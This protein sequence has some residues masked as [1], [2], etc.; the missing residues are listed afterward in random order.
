MRPVSVDIITG[1]LGSGKTTLL[2]TALAR[3][4]AGDKV[5]VV[6]NEIGDIGI[7]G[8]VITGLDHIENAIELSSGCICCSIED[9]RFD[10]AI[11]ELVTT[12]DPALIVIETT[13][14]ADPEP[15]RLRIAE[16]GLGLDATTCVVDGLNYRRA[17]VETRI[18]RRQ[19]ETADFLVLNKVD[20]IDEREKAAALRKLRRL[21]KR[22]LVLEAERGVV[23]ETLLFATSARKQR[24][25]TT[26]QAADRVM[27]HLKA[28]DIG[29]YA[30][31]TDSEFDRQRF[32]RMLARLPGTIYRAK[33]FVRFQGHGWGCLFNYTCGR[34]ELNWVKLAAMPASS[35]AVFIGRSMQEA[36]PGILEGLEACKVG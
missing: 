5:A 26:V 12:V 9:S 6:V 29:S 22:A 30:Y 14:V 15:L 4:L 17:M 3:S 7:D 2:R 23:D 34:S 33:G 10:L 19:I 21:N 36:V 32:E 28:D 35:Q 18:A 24:T 11:Q 8:R 25:R 13:G 20:L 31:T 27:G 1:F 16:A